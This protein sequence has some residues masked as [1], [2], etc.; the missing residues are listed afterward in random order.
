[1]TKT[2]NVECVV[3]RECVVCKKQAPEVV[4]NKRGKSCKG[5]LKIKREN[6]KKE[7]LEEE[8]KKLEEEKKKNSKECKSCNTVKEKQHFYKNRL[9]CKQ[10]ILIKSK[11][12]YNANKNKTLKKRGRK[13]MVRTEIMGLIAILPHDEQV[14][15]LERLKG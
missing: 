13:T 15:L 14:K 6:K 9:V 4:F 2:E 11:E 1:M 5:C 10:C 3:K 8:L 7:K 12:K